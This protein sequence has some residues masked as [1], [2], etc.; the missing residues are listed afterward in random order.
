VDRFANRFSLVVFDE[1]HHI[2]SKRRLRLLEKLKSALWLG[3]TATPG[4]STEKHLNQHFHSAHKTSIIEAIDLKLISGFRNVLVFTEAAN[5]DE[6]PLNA[7]GEFAESALESA[8]NTH[9]E[10]WQRLTSINQLLIQKQIAPA[11][12]KRNY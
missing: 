5:L 3:L 1:A 12:A 6:I 10:I 11:R 4:F 2:L 9:V 7:C 8:L